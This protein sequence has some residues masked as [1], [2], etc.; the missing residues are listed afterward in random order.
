MFNVD[1]VAIGY[2][3]ALLRMKCEQLD[4]EGKLDQSDMDSCPGNSMNVLMLKKSAIS[5]KKLEYI[6]LCIVIVYNT[7]VKFE[8]FY[9]VAERLHDYS[10]VLKDRENTNLE[11]TTEDGYSRLFVCKELLVKRWPHFERMINTPMQ[12]S[13]SSKW[14]LSV[15]ELETVETAITFVT[16]GIIHRESVEQLVDVY[17]FSDAYDLPDLKIKID[18]HLSDTIDDNSVMRVMHFA[19]TY[20]LAKLKEKAIAYVVN[21]VDDEEIFNLKDY[22]EVIK[23]SLQISATLL[24][25]CLREVKRLKAF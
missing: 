23:Q 20:S 22:D 2:D 19:D 11:V 3:F 21:N 24:Q 17:K 8:L 16:I 9:E 15:W 13:L 10:K 6:E 12:E 25:R 5:L 7:H 14:D 4:E 18:K 1:R